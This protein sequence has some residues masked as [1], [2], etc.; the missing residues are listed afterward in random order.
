M[1]VR[2][3]HLIPE[4][5]KGGHASQIDPNLTIRNNRFLISIHI[6]PEGHRVISRTFPA[7]ITN[8]IW[9]QLIR[10]NQA[11]DWT[12]VIVCCD[13]L[14]IPWHVGR[15]QKGV[16]RKCYLRAVKQKYSLRNKSL[17]RKTQFSSY[18]SLWF[19]ALLFKNHSL[20]CQRRVRLINQN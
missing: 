2:P 18:L 14:D 17:R 9:Y 4:H 15:E 16:T 5:V 1:T 12:S 19:W 8:Y 13:T 6:Q 20:S 11:C 7:P 10:F 3:S